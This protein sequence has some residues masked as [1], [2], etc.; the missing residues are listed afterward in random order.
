MLF[1]LLL[2]AADLA[3]NLPLLVAK[4]CGALEVLVA[5]GR[6]LLRADLLE[7][8]LERRHLGRRGLRGEA[9][10]RTRLVDHVDRLVRQ[11]P[12]GDVAL[13]KLGGDRQRNVG[14]RHVVMI[15]VTLAKSLENLHRLIHRR[16]I[17]DDGLEAAL[18]RAV[19]L[20]VL[21]VL[22]ERARAHA[23]Q[24]APRQRRLQH[25]GGIDCPLC[26]ARTDQRVQLVDEQNHVL[27]LRNLV[28][29]SL[30]PLLELS[31]ILGAG[32]D[33]CHVQRQHAIV[34]E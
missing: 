14:N 32:D 27:V 11:E 24:F 16:R 20:D 23:L 5:H 12:V 26:R 21:A 25:V 33:R 31:A 30:E 17:D 4:R 9:R 15:L 13:G 18:Q 3:L 7:I 19:L 1:P 8:Q 34:A 10:P 28:H 29:H 22:V 6:L 2:L